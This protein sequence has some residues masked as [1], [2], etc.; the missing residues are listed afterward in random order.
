MAAERNTKGI[1]KRA[2]NTSSAVPEP[3]TLSMIVAGLVVPTLL[4][5]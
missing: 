1:L 2:L 3:G 5:T 4:A